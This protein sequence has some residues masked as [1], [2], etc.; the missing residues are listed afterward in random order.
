MSDCSRAQALDIRICCTGLWFLAEDISNF[1]TSRPFYCR[2][3]RCAVFLHSAKV[4]HIQVF[5]GSTLAHIARHIPL[6]LEKYARLLQ[7]TSRSYCILCTLQLPG[8]CS[9]PVELLCKS[10]LASGGNWQYSTL[11]GHPLRI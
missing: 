5:T 1:A 2:T 8:S 9:E 3:A 11:A 4:A 7:H 6:A 10:S